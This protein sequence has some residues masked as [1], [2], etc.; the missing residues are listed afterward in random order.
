MSRHTVARAPLALVAAVVTLLALAV[1]AFA[2]TTTTRLSGETPVDQAVAWSQASFADGS[3]PDVILARDDDFADALGS[4][5]VQG[6][7]EAP[8]LLSDTLLLSPQTAAEI[9]R[10]GADKVIILGGEE[11]IAPTVE[12][13]LTALGLDTERIAGPTRLETAV[14]IVNRFFPNTTDVVLARAFGTQTDS[15]QAFADSLTVA[16]FS[17]AS[18]IPS[19]LTSTDTLDDPTAQALT[20]LPIQRVLVVGGTDAV[21]ENVASAAATAIDDG[22]SGTDETVTRIEG[23]NRFATAVALNAEL[24]YSSGAD[25]PRIILSEGQNDTS[26]ASG[27]PAGAQAGNGAAIVLSNGTELPPETLTFLDGA[28]RPLICGPGVEQAACDAAEAAINS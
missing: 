23:S 15:T 24:R 14:A 2:Q 6:L 12:T 11:A 3:A 18:N 1:P 13:A 16:P 25:A 19:L 9:A 10:L 4:G 28:G 17:A 26:W 21:S 8:L 20:A 22:D 7:L 27:F 5:A